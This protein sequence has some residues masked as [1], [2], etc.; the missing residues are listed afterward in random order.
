[1]KCKLKT[2]EIYD[3]KIWNYWQTPKG[4]KEKKRTWLDKLLRR[5]FAIDWMW[6]VETSEGKRWLHQGDYIVT[7]SQGNQRVYTFSEFEDK[8]EVVWNIHEEA[9]KTRESLGIK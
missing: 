9:K 5:P 3:V 4:V 1:M 8:F 6:Y 7:D 2:P